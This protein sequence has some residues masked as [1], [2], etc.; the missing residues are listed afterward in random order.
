MKRI[1]IIG[2][3]GH[4]KVMADLVSML[5]EYTLIGFA[6]SSLETGTTVIGNANV[7][8]KPEEV[9]AQVADYFIVAVGNNDIREKIFNNLKSKLKPAVLIH[10]SASVSQ[11]AS[12]APGTMVCANAVVS[13]GAKIG[14]NNI[15]NVSSVV[16]HGTVIGNHCHI[17][18]GTI[19]AGNCTIPDKTT[20]ALGELIDS[21]YYK[22]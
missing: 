21:P 19:I 22:K 12:I 3:G 11:Y 17:R 4:G 20:T 7:L 6:D 18:Q 13:V 15:L 10:P 14:E 9:N 2:A 16:D 5:H 1:I 8:C